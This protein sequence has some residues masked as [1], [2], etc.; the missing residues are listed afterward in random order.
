MSD[1]QP[2][3]YQ[4][5]ITR[6]LDGLLR[7]VP[8]RDL[9]DRRSLD[10]AD[11][12][13]TLAR[14]LAA[15]TRRALR[16]VRGENDA[17]R[18]ARQ[19]EIVN[20]V[21]DLIGDLVPEAASPEEMVEAAEELMGVARSRDRDAAGR[22]RFPARP[23]IPL[24]GSALLVNG[25]GQPEI[26]HELKRELASADRVDLLC[27]FVKWNGVRVLAEAIEEFLQRGGRLRVVT[28]TYI[29]ATD[30]LAL[31]RLAAMGAEIRVSYDTRMTRLH[32]KAW[33]FHRDNGLSTAYV[34]SSNLS[35]TALSHGLEWNVRLAQAEQP[36]LID[37]FAATF[38]DYWGDP[39]FE[40][41]D[42]AQ[43][44]ERLDRALSAERAGGRAVVL[45]FAHVDVRPYS[46]QRE[47][48][49]EL[50]AERQIHDR[51]RNLVVMA[52]GTG[53]TVVAA[54]DYRRL[55]AAG[56]AESLLFVAHR[57]EILRQSLFTFR[58]VMRDETFGELYVDGARPEQ[59]RHVFASVQTLH[60]NPLPEPDRFDMVVVDEFHH[61]E[62]ATYRRLLSGMRPK[63]LLGLTATPER[64]DGQDIKHWFGGRIAAELRLWEALE[65]GLLA[66]FQYF[67]V[68][69][70]TDLRR[71]GW[72]RGQG[73]D[74]GQLSNVYTGNDRRAA[75]V[76]ET[77][78]RKVG[79]VGR[80]RAIGFCVSVDH[81][82]FMA[83][84]FTRAGL[85]SVAVTTHSRSDERDQALRDLR[86]R[87]INAVFTV[88]L[89]NEGVDVPEIDTVLFLRPTDS[90]TVFLQ[91]L[92]RGL[93]L[94]DDKPCLTVLD[95]VGH[96]HKQ[97]RFDRRYRALTGASRTGIA[98]EIEQGFPT[99]PA[100]CVIDLDRDVRRLVLE[101]VRQALTLNWR[102]LARE[103][104][105]LGDVG[106]S[107]FLRETGLEVEDLYRRGRQ[108]WASL[109]NTAGLAAAAPDAGLGRAF[110]RM[111]HIDDVERLTFVSEV[112][113]G[114]AP[115]SPR[116]LRLMAMLDA[117]LWGGAEPASGMEA[118]LARLTGARA[119]EL[120]ELAD[121]LRSGI[122][123]VAPPL[124]PVVPL[125][126]HARYSKNEVLA[127]FGIDRPAH[128]REGVKYV[129]E[130][131]ADLF[132]VTVDKSEDHYSP[133]TLYHDRAISEELFQWESQSTLRSSTATARRYLAGESTV[134]L[135]IRQSKRD[136]GLGA[137]PYTYAGPMRYVS[138]EGERPIRF[139]WRLD[140]PLPPEVFHYAKA[141]AG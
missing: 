5:L 9:V 38:D 120:G 130:H 67:G 95:F 99:L 74:L 57:K 72:R 32:A 63:V 105:E 77:L 121:V 45:D 79:E 50:A 4:H 84:R 59:W 14:H 3:V 132:F 56:Q 103:L 24:T 1:L 36:H 141:T 102:D 122:R 34:G 114:R 64:A 52:T 35:R 73:Y 104:R 23:V 101:N 29:G 42:P 71:I 93:R 127:A 41:Y 90:A 117:M 22:V 47:I 92:G 110:G 54:L 135:L 37:T 39:S 88:D 51:W 98:R 113:A 10:L 26:G 136:E 85:P 129:P 25:R 46:Y 107:A 28:T 60:A 15:L 138:H 128:M 115:R 65:R 76:L 100:G 94:A 40:P 96:Q 13:E 43:D 109:R 18:L 27:A 124:D 31:D 17:V 140:H 66:P 8:D 137:P 75:V 70:G 131:R 11:S 118:R 83:D 61:A 81:A 126:V 7:A 86:E 2:G 111:L 69:D 97:F 49:D 139:V 119:A 125:L 19:V 91:Q 30:R 89:F 58:Q 78:R 62:A 16:S 21:A 68:H 48:L 123:H 87:R 33:L 53:K 134:H 116:E 20:R 106:M 12:H 55:R 112:L 108:G 44:A 80:M 133:T 6:E 82:R